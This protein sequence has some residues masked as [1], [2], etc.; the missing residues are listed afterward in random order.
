TAKGSDLYAICTEWPQGPFAIEGIGST[1]GIEIEM[2]GL[3][4][5][6]SWRAEG[7]RL[8]LSPPEI[9]PLQVPCQHAYC[10]R[11]RNALR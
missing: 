3:A 1:E 11:I 4:Q 6:I 10:F 7:E 5:P 8:L 2:L 9:S